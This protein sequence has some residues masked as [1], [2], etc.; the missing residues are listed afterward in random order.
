MPLGIPHRNA[1]GHLPVVHLPSLK[2]LSLSVPSRY[3]AIGAGGAG[4]NTSKFTAG[5]Q[6]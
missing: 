5:S 6:K 4:T 1:D 2:Q 3:I